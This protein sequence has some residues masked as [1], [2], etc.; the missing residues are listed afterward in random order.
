MYI[1]ELKFIKLIMTKI[2][3]IFISLSSSTHSCLFLRDHSR[4]DMPLSSIQVC[5][6]LGKFTSTLIKKTLPADYREISLVFFSL[7]LSLFSLRF[8]FYVVVC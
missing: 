5:S 8:G 3:F 2:I 7:M 4:I 1:A 6:P